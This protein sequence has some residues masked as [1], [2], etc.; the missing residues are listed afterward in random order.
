MKEFRIVD[1]EN[2]VYGEFD[3]IV[4]ACK[5]AKRRGCKVLQMDMKSKTVKETISEE[6]V[7]YMVN[8]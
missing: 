2:N 3:G 5:E 4:S 8:K 1:T 7:N 6:V